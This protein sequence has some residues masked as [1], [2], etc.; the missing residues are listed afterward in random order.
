M[1]FMIFVK[2]SKASEA[3]VMPSQELLQAMGKYNQELIAAGI[4]LDG[5][6]LRPTSKGARVT[7][8]GKDRTVSMGP[9]PNTPEL[10]A[11]YWIWKCNSLEEA[12]N[13]VK[14]APNPMLETSDIEIRPFFEDEDFDPAS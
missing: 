9:F 14:R 2:A 8:S 3:G 11:G 4:M 5:G 1:R 6:G 12:I 13:W 10:V 7:F